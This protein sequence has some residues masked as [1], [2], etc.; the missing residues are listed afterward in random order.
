M[1]ITFFILSLFVVTHVTPSLSAAI[2]LFDL[3]GR[4]GTGLRFDNENPANATGSGTG[5]EIGAGITF[6]DVT[7]VLTLN[8]GWGSGNGFTDLTG[9]VTVAHIHQAPNALFTSNGGVIINL[10]GLTPGFNNSATNGGWTNTQVTLTGAQAIALASGFLYLNVHT[11][12]NPGGEI[13][14]NLVAVPEPTTLAMLSLIGVGASVVRFRR[15]K[16]KVG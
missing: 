12:A 4:S 13:R 1:K 7:S 9:N 16:N 6:D 15:G 3:N 8:V 14:G 5:G 2:V 11:S 10:G